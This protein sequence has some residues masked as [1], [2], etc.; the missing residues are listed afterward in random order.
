MNLARGLSF[1]LG[2]FSIPFGNKVGYDLA[3]MTFALILFASWFP[4]VALMFYG[5]GWRDK[6]GRPRFHQYI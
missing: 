2:F 6:L 3:W 1:C 4:I 5:E